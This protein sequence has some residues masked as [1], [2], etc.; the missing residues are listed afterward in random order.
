MLRME[1]IAHL[2][3]ARANQVVVRH[4]RLA[5]N[6]LIFYALLVLIAAAGVPYGT[7]EAWWV[8]AFEAGIFAL[9]GLWAIELWLN[10][11]GHIRNYRLLWPLVGILLLAVIQI[12]PF[13]VGSSAGSHATLPISFDPYETG[14]FV[15]KLLALILAGGL[16]LGHIGTR[17]RLRTLVHFV[18][19]VG[20]ASGLYGI[21]RA[22]TN[23]TSGDVLS[24]DLAAG[25]GQF[26][27]RNHFAFLAEMALGL[28]LGL[29]FA[30]GFRRR[31]FLI[32]A[33]AGVIVWVA[34]VMANSR[35]GL[36][37]MM[38]QFAFVMLVMNVAPLP[39]ESAG[40]SAV[41]TETLRRP[42]GPLVLRVAVSV[43]LLMAIA[44][45]VLWVGGQPLAQRLE[46]N[47]LAREF[48]A[49]PLDSTTRIRRLDMWSA[50]WQLIKH[51]PVAGV[52]FGGYW[53]A[54]PEYLRY[55]GK[56]E[57]HQAH[58]DY[59]EI[60]ASGGLIG[61]ALVAWFCWAVIAGAR[62][63]LVST[64]PFQRA[65]CLGALTGLFGV[66]VH[67]LVDFG[68]HVTINALVFTALLVIATAELERNNHAPVVYE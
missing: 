37:S 24:S 33:A 51:H 31:Q 48:N 65:A 23:N 63:R 59:L 36:L 56:K 20:V 61:G 44:F 8:A 66:A 17:S 58:N 57:L 45:G 11:T 29:L 27:N 49:A 19:G 21:V 28:L 62:R 2:E 53:L 60:L 50:T 25:F 6:P 34:L 39:R 26:V 32:Y 14:R 9:V 5:L 30:G 64:D 42:A 47:S 10:Q 4:S 46:E 38:G 43:C 15:F 18:I 7:V 54:I 41:T 22:M 67:S 13:T 35:G 3:S 1:A 55:S 40:P 52:G 12:I 16:M 68:L